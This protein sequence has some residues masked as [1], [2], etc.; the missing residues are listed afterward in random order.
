[1]AFFSSACHI[2]DSPV[3]VEACYSFRGITK[4]KHVPLWE[5]NI[6]IQIYFAF[7]FEIDVTKRLQ[8][9]WCAT[10]AAADCSS[11]DDPDPNLARGTSVRRVPSLGDP[12]I[13]YE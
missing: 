2:C 9:G 6:S 12:L 13:N 8:T 7:T 1:M 5:V 3:C 11:R 10:V 4:K